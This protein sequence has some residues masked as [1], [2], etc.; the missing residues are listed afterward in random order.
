[1]VGCHHELVESRERVAVAILR[2]WVEPGTDDTLKIRVTTARDVTATARTIAVA[3][4][5]DSACAIIRSWL[6]GFAT[7]ARPSGDRTQ[8]ENGRG[9]RRP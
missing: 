6:E 2:A 8:H 7:P 4:D 3:A 5:I 9:M 1:M